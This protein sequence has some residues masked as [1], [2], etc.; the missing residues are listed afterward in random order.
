M[1]LRLQQKMETL[2]KQRQ[3]LEQVHAQL[4]TLRSNA[5]KHEQEALALNAMLNQGS[6]VTFKYVCK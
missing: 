4:K 1:L 2:T 6:V 5:E 3:D